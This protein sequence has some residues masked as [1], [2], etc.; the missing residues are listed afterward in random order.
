LKWTLTNREDNACYIKIICNINDNQRI[1]GIHILG[2]NSGE[3]LQGFA[4]AMK[5]GAT[6]DDLD[7]VVG[8]HPTIAEEL[9]LLRITKSSGE[10]PQ[11]TGC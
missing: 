7:S 8:I 2:P 5:M 11:K 1:L 10:D 3:I 4:V 6:K 9:V